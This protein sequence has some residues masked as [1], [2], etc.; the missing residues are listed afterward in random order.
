MSDFVF[1]NLW[2][3]RN[4]YIHNKNL[5]NMILNTQQDMQH[6]TEKQKRWNTPLF[7]TNM[8]LR[9]ELH[10][11]VKVKRMLSD[12]ECHLLIGQSNIQFERWMTY[13]HSAGKKTLL[14]IVMYCLWTF[15]KMHWKTLFL[16]S[17]LF[18]FLV[19]SKLKD[20]G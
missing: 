9:T 18:Q 15:N 11:I 1:K 8:E 19:N 12:M 20:L 13:V 7:E 5:N 17:V 3:K 10:L 16:K 6:V 2:L 14:L 4:G